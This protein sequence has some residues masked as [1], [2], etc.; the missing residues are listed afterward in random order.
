MVLDAIATF[1]IVVLFGMFFVGIPLLFS[2]LLLFL[3][4]PSDVEYDESYGVF[5]IFREIIGYIPF[6]KDS[7]DIVLNVTVDGLYRTVKAMLVGLG[8]FFA[9]LVLAPDNLFYPIFAVYVLGG[10]LVMGYMSEWMHDTFPEDSG[11]VEIVEKMFKVR[12]WVY[13]MGMGAG[14]MGFVVVALYVVFR[15]S[16]W[17]GVPGFVG[18]LVFATIAVIGF[19]GYSGVVIRNNYRDNFEG[20][21]D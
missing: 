16:S 10:F 20:D 15:A 13:V 9:L 8:P 4:L 11:T 7:E 12:T 6:V 3:P 1:M 5:A 17:F 18:W 14:M 2:K 19:M 21:E